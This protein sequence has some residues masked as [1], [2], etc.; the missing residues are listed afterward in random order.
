MV[1]GTG[2]LKNKQQLA[3]EEESEVKGLATTTMKKQERSS[4]IKRSWL[5]G[6]TK[7][8]RKANWQTKGK[9]MMTL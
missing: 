9:S 5:A 7:S 1:A 8:E 4:F 6:G 2:K 3:Q